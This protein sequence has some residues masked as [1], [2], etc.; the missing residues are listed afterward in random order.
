M[1]ATVP[2]GTPR[3]RGG[4]RQSVVRSSLDI[5]FS[6]SRSQQRY[7]AGLPSAPS[8]VDS[9]WSGDATAEDDEDR[10]WDTEAGGSR[11][12]YS[13]TDDAEA[14]DTSSE[15][16]AFFVGDPVRTAGSRRGSPNDL[17]SILERRVELPSTGN[18]LPTKRGGLL[19]MYG[20]TPT[21]PLSSSQTSSSGS[22]TNSGGVTP[23]AGNKPLP[24]DLS[25]RRV[26]VQRGVGVGPGPVVRQRLA[27]ETTP[28]LGASP[29]TW[30]PE[31]LSPSRRSSVVSHRRV[32]HRAPP[33]IGESSDGQTLFN[34]TAVLVG[35]GLLSMPL[36]F[37][38]AGWIGGTI[39]LIGFSYL[40]CTTA[41]MMANLIFA[42]HSLAGYTDIGLAAFGPAAGGAI[43]LLFCLELFAIGV[44]LMV[45]LGDSL[46]ALF[47]SISSNMWKILGLSVILPTT[48]MPLW[49]LSFPSVISTLCTVLLI[50]IVVF[51]GVWKTEAPG[52]L[53]DPMP[54]HV[55]PQMEGANWLGGVGL[56]LA[57]FGGH[58]VIPSI[59]RDMK[60]PGSANRVFNIAFT[61]AG[62]IAFAA[63][64]TGYL[65]FGDNVSDQITRDLKNPKYGYPAILNTIAVWMIISAPVSKFGLC[66]RPLNIAVEGFLGLAPNPAVHPPRDRRRSVVEQVSSSLGTSLA[67]AGASDYIADD[68]FEDRPKPPVIPLY[69]PNATRRGEGWKGI[70][71]IASRTIITIGCTATAI[72]LPGFEKVMAFLG[73]FS[74]FLICIILPLGFYLRLSPKLLHLDLND[75]NV[76]ISRGIQ[77]AVILASTLMMFLGTAWAFLPK[78]A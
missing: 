71:R 76:R 42:D 61:I 17:T 78:A 28:L 68:L 6:Y 27:S 2:I 22:N 7:F 35:I 38:Y 32:S 43:N 69:D 40:T 44:A 14:I 33:H 31:R 62:I 70:A 57:G 15:A 11:S 20:T 8:F 72:L 60:H 16:S 21:V 65:M 66:S 52:S 30:Q 64:A 47:P 29:K 19:Q 34:A 48:F 4:R 46:H 63:G 49:L 3:E 23:R 55:G 24:D 41:K 74:S 45:L 73:S 9:H 10:E 12:G 1:P 53:T 75:K 13:S 39:M 25:A 59:A 77:V 37:S 5:V 51:D 67:A 36:A 18:S 58:A 54:T 56:V 50:G 26:S